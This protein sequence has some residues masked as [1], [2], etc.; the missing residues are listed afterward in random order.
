MALLLAWHG[1]RSGAARYESAARAIER[2]VATAIQAGRAT[3]DVGGTF[4]TAATG[5]AIVEILQ[6]DASAA[7]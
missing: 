5:Q 6:S 3:R 2:A 7:R 4:G 1:E